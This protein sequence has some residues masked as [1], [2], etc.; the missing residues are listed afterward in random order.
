MKH[1]LAIAAIIITTSAQAYTP[2][3]PCYHCDRPIPSVGVGHYSNHRTQEQTYKALVTT[4]IALS[5]IAI[6]IELQ[7]SRIDGQVRI[8]EFQNFQNGKIRENGEIMKRIIALFYYYKF[9]W[10]GKRV[11]IFKAS[12]GSI[13]IQVRNS[14]GRYKDKVRISN[15]Y[16]KNSN[17]NI[18]HLQNIKEFVL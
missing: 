7:P 2:L 18:R 6:L 1:I 9:K 14:Q 17:G 10:Q 5:V 11:R 12:T 4:A 3:R 13:Y 8:A 15:H 16:S